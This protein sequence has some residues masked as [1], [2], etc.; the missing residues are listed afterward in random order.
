MSG[1]ARENKTALRQELLER[2]AARP[3]PEHGAAAEALA[4]HVMASTALVRPPRAACYLPMPGEPDTRLLIAALRERGIEVVVPVSRPGDRSL[5]W[6]AV[7]DEHPVAG[8]HGIAEP[9]GPRLGQAAL[10][11]CPVAFVPA[12]AVDHAGHRL[13]RG[14][15]YY[16]RALTGYSGLT[17][18]VVFT[19]ELLPALP[20]EEHD[21]PVDL[22]LTPGGI[23]RPDR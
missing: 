1:S 3:S 17:C 9:L 15:G 8:A 16:D 11:S 2:R 6:V 21:V 4:L 5:D 14:A 23:F 13:G 22:A 18:A 7:D 10:R 12:L 20:V 19:E